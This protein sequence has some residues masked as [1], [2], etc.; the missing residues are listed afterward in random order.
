M[1][2]ENEIAQCKDIYLQ[3]LRKTN[4]EGIESLIEWLEDSDFF[5]SPASTIYHGNYAGGLCE[6]S[7]NVNNCLDY[8]YSNLK[9]SNE[10]NIPDI[11]MTSLK[12]VALLHDICKANTYIPGTRN[13]KNEQ[14][15][16]WEK[17][18]TF[19]R[20][21]KFAMGHASKSLF[22]AQK[23]IQLSP[24]EAQAIFWHM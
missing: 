3:E 12:L 1:L 6:H 16:Q 7:L 22:I 10:F 11:D 18:P 20:E 9:S 17:V 13:V 21:P 4:R 19:R 15:G 14:T 2:T 5:Y 8:L 24:D 23:F